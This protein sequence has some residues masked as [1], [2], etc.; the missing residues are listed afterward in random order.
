MLEQSAKLP[1]RDVRRSALS[2]LEALSGE[3]FSHSMVFYRGIELDR[4]L[5]KKM[6]DRKDG[7]KGLTFTREKSKL[8][9]ARAIVVSWD[10]AKSAVVILL[11]LAIVRS[12][13]LDDP[14]L[15]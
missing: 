10:P 8:R 14:L 12:R 4:S 7:R 9:F 13:L 6:A 1:R 11:M 5:S 3:R 2:C 15:I